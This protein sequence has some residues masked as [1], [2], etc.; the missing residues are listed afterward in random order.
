MAFSYFGDRTFWVNSDNV[1]FEF[2]PLQWVW[3]TVRL[4]EYAAPGKGSVA[5]ASTEPG[6]SSEGSGTEGVTAMGCSCSSP[7][8]FQLHKDKKKYSAYE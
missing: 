3:R 6:Y 8:N 7:Q 2:L 5:G 1:H 4:E